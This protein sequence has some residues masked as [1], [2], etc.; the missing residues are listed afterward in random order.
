MPAP[1]S[2]NKS[3]LNV[4]HQHFT[5]ILKKKNKK[6]VLIPTFVWKFCQFSWIEP[7]PVLSCSS[8]KRLLNIPAQNLQNFPS[9]LWQRA[10]TWSQRQLRLSTR[11]IASKLLF[12]QRTELKQHL[13]ERPN[14]TGLPWG[15]GH[16]PVTICEMPELLQTIFEQLSTAS[17]CAGV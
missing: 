9:R 17:L 13:H 7:E 6:P 11:P 12:A 4:R 16:Q 8:L 10:S 5:K 15:L 2:T 1:A 3:W 14:D